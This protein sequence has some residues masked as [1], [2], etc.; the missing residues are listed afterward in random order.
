MASYVR[1]MKAPCM[2]DVNP[3]C[4]YFQLIALCGAT[5]QSLLTVQNAMI[6]KYE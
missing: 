5:I 2:Q 1:E 6:I 4:N 3:R